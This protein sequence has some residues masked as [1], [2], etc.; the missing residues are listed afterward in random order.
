MRKI[1]SNLNQTFCQTIFVVG[2]MVLISLTNLFLFDNSY[3][4]AA[5]YSTNNLTPEEK[6]DR[7]Y[8]YNEAAGFEEENRQEAYKQAIKD[9]KSPQ[10]LEKAYERNLKAENVKEPNILE[11]TGQLIQNATKK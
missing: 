6:I 10:S 4:Y 1:L 2:L 7:A 11:Q 8:E 9:S 3:S 5:T